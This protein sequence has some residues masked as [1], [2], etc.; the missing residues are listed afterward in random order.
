MEIGLKDRPDERSAAVDA[1]GG[2]CGA[3]GVAADL[4]VDDHNL[5]GRTFAKAGNDE[6]QQREEQNDSDG[7]ETNHEWRHD[8][9]S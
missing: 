6:N 5:V 1:A 4:A 8:E 3:V 2:A 9:T 7:N